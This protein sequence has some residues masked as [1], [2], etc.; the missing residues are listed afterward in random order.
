MSVMEGETRKAL[1]DIKCLRGKDLGS[2]VFIL[3][4]T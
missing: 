3:F 4:E 1:F 2:M